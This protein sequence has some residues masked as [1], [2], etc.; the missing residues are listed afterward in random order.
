MLVGE[1]EDAKYYNKRA[2]L[3]S[4]QYAANVIRKCDFKSYN[5]CNLLFESQST[6]D[7]I[8]CSLNELSLMEKKRTNINK[9]QITNNNNKQQTTTTTNNNSNNTNNNKQQLTTTTTTTTTT[10]N[11]KQPEPD[12]Y[13]HRK[14][15]ITHNKHTVFTTS[16][17]Y[18]MS[19]A[20]S[21]KINPTIEADD[22]MKM[23][24]N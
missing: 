15:N 12:D 7:S 17:T 2:T 23:E 14:M 3:L 10:N 16:E 1:F 6:M 5:P 24:D 11:K 4:H 21:I 13:F 8:S 19:I 9:Q 18:D 22:D 20:N